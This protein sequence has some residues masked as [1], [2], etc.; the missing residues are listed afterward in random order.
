MAM[1]QYYM[2]RGQE[3]EEDEYPLNNSR[4][5]R[6]KGHWIQRENQ[7]HKL[8]RARTDGHSPTTESSSRNPEFKLWGGEELFDQGGSAWL[9]RSK[10]FRTTQKEDV[11]YV[12]S[13]FCRTDCWLESGED[14]SVDKERMLRT[15]GTA[16]FKRLAE[17][18]LR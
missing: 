5:A 10:V 11:G 7:Y 1:K 6:G 4:S 15:R 17:W 16:P 18:G 14:G 9:D 12:G 3:L 13:I 2:L 8:L